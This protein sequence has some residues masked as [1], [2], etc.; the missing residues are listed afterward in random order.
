MAEYLRAFLHYICEFRT[1]RQLVGFAPK[2]RSIMRI[3]VCCVFAHEDSAQL[4]T[5]KPVTEDASEKAACQMLIF[6]YCQ[7]VVLVILVQPD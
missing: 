6:F 7:V 1:H 2:Q 4:K 5:Q 3:S